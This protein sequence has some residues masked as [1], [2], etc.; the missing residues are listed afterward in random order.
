MIL[1]CTNELSGTTGYHKSVVELANG[2]HRAGYPLAILSFLGTSDGSARALSRWPLDAGIPAFV[3]QTL[4]ADGGRLLH[5]NYHPVFTARLGAAAFEFTENQLAVLRQLNAALTEEDTILF[6]AP[7]PAYVFHHALGGAPRSAKTVLQIHSD[8]RF[9]DGLWEMLTESR[10]SIDRLQTVSD[11][12]RAQFT[13]LFDSSH[14][15]FVPNFPGHHGRP[16]S[17]AP[18]DGVNIALPASFQPRKN[19]LDAVRALALIEDERVHLTLWGNNGRR[20]PYFVSVE[21]LAQELGVASRVHT[22]GF[23]AEADV[24]STADIVLMTSLSEGF[25]YPLVEAMYHGRPTVSYDFEHGPREAIEDGASGYIVPMGEVEQLADRLASVAADHALRA[26]FGARAR[27]LFEERFSTDAVTE[28]Y[29]GLLGPVGRSLDVVD[30]F[31]TDGGDPVATQAIGHRHR[32]VKGRGRHRVTV[33]STLELHDIE[34]DNGERVMAA[35]VR[36]LRGATRIEFEAEGDEVISYATTSK[37][38]DRHYLANTKGSRLEVLPYLCRGASRGEGTTSGLDVIFAASGGTR[39]LTR[40]ERAEMSR[41][42]IVR[43]SRDILWKLRQLAKP[44]RPTMPPADASPVL[45]VGSERVDDKS[46]SASEQIE[47]P[48]SLRESGGGASSEMTTSADSKT[49]S[50][51]GLVSRYRAD[52]RDRELKSAVNAATPTRREIARHPWF[53]VTSGM[54]NFG[55]PI[56][57]RGGV[58]VSNSGS[59]RRPTVSIRG[60]YDWVLL[61]DG[62]GERRVEPPFG[63]GELFE[64]ICA[65]E[66][67]HGLFDIATRDGVYPWELGR[68]AVILQLAESLGMWSK[69]N[70]TG[71]PAKDVYGG[72]KRLTAAPTAPRVVLDYPRRGQSA[73]RTVAHRGDDTLF[74]VHPT[75]SG[76]P[77]VD[78]DNLVYPMHEFLQWR[79][80]PE[81]KAALLRAADVDRRP[82]EKALSDALGLR[83]DLGNHL[84]NRLLAFLD[85][86]DFW[87][88]VFERVKPEEVLIASSH[89]WAGVSLAA[90]RVGALVSDIQYA[91]TGQYHPTFWFGGTPHYGATRFYAWSEFWAA[92]TNVYKE[93]VIVPRPQPELYAEPCREAGDLIWDVCV[94]TQPR[95]QRRILAFVDRLVRERGDLKVVIAPHPSNRHEMPR[96]LA[97]VGLADKVSISPDDTLTTVQKSVLSVGGYSTSLWEAVSLGCPTYVIPVPGHEFT[98]ADVESGLFRLASSPHDLVPYDVPDSRRSIFGAG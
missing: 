12:Q 54:D 35:S 97:A 42:M 53:P 4:P 28:R 56:N 46:S 74:V 49:S 84:R 91:D 64:R 81:R 57:E 79:Q 20:N 62:A 68:A 59:V 83:V 11:R 33:R 3:L 15:V 51:A 17:L 82:F 94:I 26:R 9:H 44:A 31:S 86:R 29:R 90:R 1:I 88:P 48:R 67:D 77:E 39:M 32:R 89:W 87:T 19:Q 27:E 76:Y 6:T 14:V 92:R 34:V 10:A 7:I 66:R 30:A 47:G 95:V 23:G 13:P 2:L 73:Y 71:E 5:R 50:V 70:A 37:S 60:E 80:N 24:Y 52:S 41:A 16:I 61:R 65:A 38:D 69:D 55:S 21:R 45:P 72:P 36:R 43:I 18:H 75:P 40:R 25:P 96:D 78:D 98:L 85:Q 93:H 58:E 22:P 8:Y 63:Y